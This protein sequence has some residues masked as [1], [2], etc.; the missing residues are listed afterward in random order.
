MIESYKNTNCSKQQLIQILNSKENKKINKLIDQLSKTL[1][2]NDIFLLFYEL[3]QNIF[4]SVESSLFKIEDLVFIL[5]NL[6]K[7]HVTKLL[8]IFNNF[9]ISD[10]TQLKL[11]LKNKL[12]KVTDK[13]KILDEPILND[14]LKGLNIIETDTPNTN[15]NNT[16]N[17]NTL[18]SISNLN[19]DY[20]FVNGIIK[21]IEQ[22][23]FICSQKIMNRL[24]KIL[25][26]PSKKSPITENQLCEIIKGLKKKYVQNKSFIA[27]LNYHGFIYAIDLIKKKFN[28][29]CKNVN[30]IYI[31]IIKEDNGELFEY[32]LKNNK[33]NVS[34]FDEKIVFQIL[35][36]KK[37]NIINVLIKYKCDLSVP[38]T[39]IL[40]KKNV[41]RRA[42]K[43]N[44]ERIK[45]KTK[46]FEMIT[47]CEKLGYLINNDVFCDI[48]TF[49][50]DEKILEYIESKKQFK[51]KIYS[52]T[53]YIK[54]IHLIMNNIKKTITVSQYVEIY[55]YHITKY[56]VTPTTHIKSD[57][58]RSLKIKLVKILVEEYNFKFTLENIES[59]MCV[60]GKN[61]WWVY[62]NSEKNTYK[63]VLLIDYLSNKFPKIKSIYQNNNL[64]KKLR[65]MTHKFSD[66][67]ILFLLN[68][69]QIIINEELLGDIMKQDRPLLLTS[70]KYI[71]QNWQESIK[72]IKKI[73]VTNYVSM[74][75][76][77]ILFDFMNLHSI[78]ITQEEVLSKIFNKQINEELILYLIDCKILQIDTKIITLFV[79][80][81]IE[82]HEH[83]S[84]LIKALG[85]YKKIT[86]KTFEHIQNATQNMKEELKSK[87]IYLDYYMKKIIKIFESIIQMKN[88]FTIIEENIN[89]YKILGIE[90]DENNFDK[91]QKNYQKICQKIL[92]SYKQTFLENLLS[93]PFLNH[94]RRNSRDSIYS[95]D[96]NSSDETIDLD[97]QNHSN[98]ISDNHDPNS[99]DDMSYL[100]YSNCMDN[101]FDANYV[102]NMNHVDNMNYVDNV[103]HVNHVQNHMI[104]DNFDNLLNGENYIEKR[105]INK[106]KIID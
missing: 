42:N 90:I 83:E 2:R 14:Y 30:Q 99:S 94:H 48:L 71:L 9:I 18:L 82:T 84:I 35:K 104:E 8:E 106:I 51:E 16:N 7:F 59:Y 103:N 22:G 77:P 26:V 65:K 95:H 6:K 67:T 89:S 47:L 12:S 80:L 20:N 10:E 76:L 17:T 38:I 50:P 1:L 27:K 57:V 31:Q 37:I 75:Y 11:L 13:I 33:I 23:T 15:T 49:L 97:Y 73:F 101:P 68:N 24:I 105:V 61:G 34:N 53:E 85:L 41:I 60:Y 102:D 66:E 63:L 92:M 81:V 96:F 93:N 32:M 29:Q 70:I 25:N 55:A 79:L 45:E 91:S 46:A 3:D 64:Y 36:E 78:T 74:G 100:R 39:K 56:K 87:K 98:T 40:T 69:K 52:K 72:Y 44:I 62:D 86:R 21:K 28:T 58:F 19:T 43:Y 88:Q 5:G 54:N 4:N